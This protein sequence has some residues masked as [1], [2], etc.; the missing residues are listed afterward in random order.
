MRKK[1]NKLIFLL[2]GFFVVLLCGALIGGK[3]PVY[4]IPNATNNQEEK[5]VSKKTIDKFKEEFSTYWW[6][7]YT[8]SADYDKG[9]VNIYLPKSSSE[10]QEFKNLNDVIGAVAIRQY[11]FGNKDL[12]VY[13]LDHE[14]NKLAKLVNGKVV[15]SYS[16]KVDKKLVEK[17]LDEWKKANE[18]GSSTGSSTDETTSGTT[19]STQSSEPMGADLTQYGQ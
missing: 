7:D 17:R 6:K 9:E 1:R 11:R 3:D 5:V 12:R 4:S 2:F 15:E 8:V 16:E 10:G 19:D 18:S 13:L 14:K